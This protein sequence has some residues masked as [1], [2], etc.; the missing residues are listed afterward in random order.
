MAAIGQ[1]GLMHTYKELFNARGFR[2]AQVLLT[3]GDMEDRRRYLNA[4]YTLE[5][6]LELGAVPVIDRLGDEALDDVIGVVAIAQQVLPAQE[7]LEGGL[8]EGG[9]EFAQAFP[10]VLPKKAE[11]G[12][13]RGSPPGLKRPVTDLVERFADRQH[14]LEAHAGGQE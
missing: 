2:A 13:E 6:L 14:V 3:R 11:A 4:R 7:H 9:L 5:K 10:G 8:G 12:I 1:V